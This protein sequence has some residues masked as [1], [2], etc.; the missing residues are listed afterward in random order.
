MII[1]FHSFD[2][3]IGFIGSLNR[4]ERPREIRFARPIGNFTLY[5]LLDLPQLNNLRI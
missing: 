5:D 4:Q 1:Q 2:L 3:F